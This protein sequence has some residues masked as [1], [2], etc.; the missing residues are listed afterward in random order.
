MSCRLTGKSVFQHTLKTRRYWKNPWDRHNG[1]AYVERLYVPT[2]S[3]IVPYASRLQSVRFIVVH[4]IKI[5][6]TSRVF[7]T[8]SQ[9]STTKE[10]KK[11]T[12]LSK[13]ETNNESSMAKKDPSSTFLSM[14][15]NLET[16]FQEVLDALATNG[17]MSSELVHKALIS[18]KQWNFSRTTSSVMNATTRTSKTFSHGQDIPLKLMHYIMEQTGQEELWND[19]A[20]C[21]NFV[22]VLE[23]FIMS[24]RAR[25]TAEDCL[26]L[27]I[28]LLDRLETM[29]RVYPQIKPTLKSYNV[30]IDIVSKCKHRQ[31][32]I[33]EIENLIERAKKYCSELPD[34]TSY[35]SLLFAYAQQQ[36]DNDSVAAATKSESFLRK[37]QNNPNTRSLVDSVS[38][39]IVINAW[40]KSNSTRTKNHGS[41][42]ATRAENLLLEMQKHY[43]NGCDNVRPT[44]ISFTSVIHAWSRISS[45]DVDA[46]QRATDIL[47]LL[48]QS[49]KLDDKLR[50]NAYTFHAVMNAWSNSTLPNAAQRVEYFLD[51]MIERFTAGDKE[52]MPSTI[53][54]SIAIKAWTRTDDRGNGTKALALLDHMLT[55]SK[56]GYPTAPDIVTLNSVLR[57]VANDSSKVEKISDATK[58]LELI[59]DIRL[60]PDLST[61]NN[62]LRCC[63]TTRSEDVEIMQKS[64]RL[65]TETLLNIRKTPGIAP[66]PYTFNYYIKVCD[67]VTFG[68]EKIKLI[69]TAFQFCIESQ[70]FSA[71]VLSIM[72][73]A[74]T[75]QELQ[76]ITRMD[77][78][79]DLQID[80]F[81]AEWRRGLKKARNSSR[82]GNQKSN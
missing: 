44:L 68:D 69:R 80:D 37:M 61:Y 2:Q 81:P 36:D 23:S 55:L 60:N 21:E 46:A 15:K 20:L 43:V 11:I 76:D 71:P 31:D 8:Y 59:K 75:P 66:D 29:I 4:S 27:V 26:P 54:F 50:P 79:S 53:S 42:A 47:D 52:L 35:N 5:R 24:I 1:L 49:S 32:R 40:A 56:K 51:Q 82:Q 16:V 39:N 64:V 30:A 13:N 14:Q 34:S 17:Y 28:D 3:W 73:N 9:I 41:Y 45:K 77:K 48:E 25:N 70:Q 78:V 72:K 63:M 65:A 22:K 57:A 62:I 74:L 10:K 6:I 33:Q 19:S 58:M 38:Y 12:A 18:V 7:S 67:R